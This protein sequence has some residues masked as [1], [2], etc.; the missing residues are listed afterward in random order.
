MY[1]KGNPEKGVNEHQG[2]IPCWALN[3]QWN[4]EW[5]VQLPGLAFRRATAWNIFWILRGTVC[6]E[7]TTFVLRFPQ[8]ISSPGIFHFQWGDFFSLSVMWNVIGN[9]QKEIIS[10]HSG[11]RFL[12][13]GCCPAQPREDVLLWDSSGWDT[14]L[15]VDVRQTAYPQGKG[16]KWSLSKTRF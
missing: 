2:A 1:L 10:S 13:P 8:F 11:V 5:N 9:G 7:L 6:L 16:S 3:Y 14:Y 4:L 15:L 12:V